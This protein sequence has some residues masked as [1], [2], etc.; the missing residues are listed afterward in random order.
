MPTMPAKKTK[1][2]NSPRLIPDEL[3]DPL[4]AQVD[5][6]DAE[7]ILGESGLVGLLTWKQ[8][9][10]QFAIPFGERFTNALG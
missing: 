5:G 8:A 9:A 10:N 1:K 7:S 2:P 4:L 3:I 6:K